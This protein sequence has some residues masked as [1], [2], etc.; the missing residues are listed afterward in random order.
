MKNIALDIYSR[1]P[2]SGHWVEQR[3]TIAVEYFGEHY[4]CSSPLP[5]APRLR[6]TRVSN[7]NLT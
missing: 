4:E 2:A 3:P 5:H 7:V 6:P 1:A